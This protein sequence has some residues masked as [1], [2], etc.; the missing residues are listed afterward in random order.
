MLV[1]LKSKT[2]ECNTGLHKITWLRKRSH[3]V[4]YE[5]GAPHRKKMIAEQCKKHNRRGFTLVIRFKAIAIYTKL[6]KWNCSR[7]NDRNVGISLVNRFSCK[8]FQNSGTTEY[9]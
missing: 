9:T 6:K 4:H 2:C 5:V 8:G 1:P 7:N 3:C